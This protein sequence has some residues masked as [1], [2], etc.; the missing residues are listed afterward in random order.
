MNELSFDNLFQIWSCE[1]AYL[2]IKNVEQCKIF[3]DLCRSID[4]NAGIGQNIY[5]GATTAG[6]Y[7]AHEVIRRASHGWFNEIDLTLQADMDYLTDK[8]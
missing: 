3:H 8:E 6:H 4:G 2:A 1:M 7:A 5:Y